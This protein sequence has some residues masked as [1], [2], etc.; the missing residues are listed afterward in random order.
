MSV[1]QQEYVAFKAELAAS[2][3]AVAT[4][5]AKMESFA[6]QSASETQETKKVI[7]E[8][9]QSYNTIAVQSA[10]AVDLKAN[11]LNEGRGGRAQT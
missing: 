3:A 6:I 8:L 4:S 5:L 11:R 10:S 9:Q 1:S 2:D 7:G